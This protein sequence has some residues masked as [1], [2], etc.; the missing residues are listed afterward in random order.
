VL[1]RRT[2]KLPCQIQYMLIL[3]EIFVHVGLFYKSF[4]SLRN[5]KIFLEGQNS[6]ESSDK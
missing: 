3:F 1:D 2:V 5:N 6:E 4:F